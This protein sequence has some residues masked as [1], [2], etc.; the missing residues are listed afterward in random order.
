MSIRR[1]PSPGQ[2]EFHRDERGSSPRR[3]PR[4]RHGQFQ[5]CRR[6]RR[7]RQAGREHRAG[8][9]AVTLETEKATMDVPSTA[10]GVVEEVHVEKGRKVNAGDLIATVRPAGD[11]CAGRCAS[12]AAEAAKA[13]PPRRPRN[14]RRQRHGSASRCGGK[15]PTPRRS[16]A[17]PPRRSRRRQDHRAARGSAHRPASHQ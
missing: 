8:G 16:V 15:A 14:P 1:N 10:S 2:S 12:R 17:A 11:G 6:D 7:P 5:G 3:S 13:L 9:A 4:A